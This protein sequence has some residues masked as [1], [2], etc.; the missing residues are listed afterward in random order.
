MTAHT[1]RAV[2]TAA[3][4]GLFGVPAVIELV[5]L[6]T[7]PY[8]WP[9]FAGALD[10]VISAIAIALWVASAVAIATRSRELLVMIPLGTLAL[11]TY[12]LFGTISG[13][14]FGLVYIAFGAAAAIVS[15]MALAGRSSTSSQPAP[16][17]TPG[18]PDAA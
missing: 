2:A 13:S 10:W 14:Y 18:E 4:V 17:R 9:G 1:T 16:P 5:R 11:V 7:R 15:K 8:A 6:L 12:G 3:G